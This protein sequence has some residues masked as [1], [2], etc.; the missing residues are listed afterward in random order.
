MSH[1]DML[2]HFSKYLTDY[3]KSEMLKYD[4]I[5]F[6]ILERK[7]NGGPF[8]NKGSHNEGYDNEFGEYLYQKMTISSIDLRS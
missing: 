4:I 7:L 3:E 5:Y 1:E 8:K 6:N 2:T